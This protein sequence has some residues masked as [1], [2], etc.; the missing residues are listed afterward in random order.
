MYTI[1]H[2]NYLVMEYGYFLE[3]QRI[4][5]QIMCYF[6][7]TATKLLFSYLGSFNENLKLFLYYRFNI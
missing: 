6:V 4:Q 3:Q 5:S 2:L 1:L 7:K